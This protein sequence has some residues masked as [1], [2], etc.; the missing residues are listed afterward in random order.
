MQ[1]L[2]KAGVATRRPVFRT[3]HRYLGLSDDQ[4][5]HA[6]RFWEQALSLPVHPALSDEQAQRVVDEV[7]RCWPY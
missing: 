1:A 4:F 3:L 6:Q 5:P 7:G 2:D